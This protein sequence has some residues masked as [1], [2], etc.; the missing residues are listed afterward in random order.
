MNRYR[1]IPQVA[2]SSKLKGEECVGQKDSGHTHHRAYPAPATGNHTQ[3][4]GIFQHIPIGQRQHARIRNFARPGRRCTDPE[5][6]GFLQ[7]NTSAAAWIP[8]GPIAAGNRYLMAPI[9]GGVFYKWPSFHLAICGICKFGIRN[10]TNR[11]IARKWILCFSR[12]NNFCLM[13]KI[14]VDF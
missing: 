4:P 2:R 10:G 13:I 8:I 3:N 14:V 7:W 1:P 12:Y 5:R 6:P 9:R 11:E